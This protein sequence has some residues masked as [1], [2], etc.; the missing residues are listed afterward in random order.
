ML[1]FWPNL[2]YYGIS[3]NV[4]THVR[5][6][7]NIL[8]INSY[9]SPGSSSPLISSH[10]GTVPLVYVALWVVHWKVTYFWKMAWM[11]MCF[12]NMMINW[13]TWWHVTFLFFGRSAFRIAVILV[14]LLMI[15]DTDNLSCYYPTITRNCALSKNKPKVYDRTLVINS[16]RNLYLLLTKRNMYFVFFKGSNFNHTCTEYEAPV[17]NQNFWP[18]T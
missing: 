4:N 10:W 6:Q 13:W 3:R 14:D 1:L 9:C 2:Y 18:I 16:Q 17:S 12:W 5:E 11:V 7:I 8:K 15:V